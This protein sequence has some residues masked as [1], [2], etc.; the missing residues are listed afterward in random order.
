V[1][2][3]IRSVNSVLV[4]LFFS[5]GILFPQAKPAAAPQKSAPPPAKQQAAPPP[6]KAEPEEQI[7]PA[8]PDAI[9]PAVVARVNGRAVR[10][11][12]LE[13]RIQ[14][15]L[16]PMGNPKWTNLREE[17]RLELTNQQMGS[18]IAQEL[19]YQKA[20]AMAIKA[21][22][23]EIQ[24]EFDK[25][26]KSFAS[27]AEMNMT[28]ADRGLDRAG[29]TKELDRS[30]TVSKY[31]QETI[32]KKITITPAQVSEY[33][34]ANKQSFDHP[35]LIRTSHILIMVSEGATAEQDRLA[36]QRAAAI[37][38]RARKGEDFAKL[39]KENSM[40]NSASDGGDLGLVPRG[41][42]APEYEKA[43]FALP[44]G[45]ISDPVRT[46]FGYHVIKVTEKKPAGIASLEE[47][48][49]QLTEFLKS[50]KTDEEL[51]K[52]IDELRKQAKIEILIPLGSG[53]QAPG[54]TSTS[55]SRP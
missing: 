14:T 1:N 3:S 23:T 46:Q 26:A 31:V 15:Q 38:A 49:T 4:F 43:A 37:L 47:V 16:A 36:Q 44:V 24:A 48:R 10:G 54:I 20:S 22:A 5:L 9:F 51:Q 2:S 6:Q 41:Q 50:Q 30:L 11:R 7:P 19:I 32:G 17:Y 40:D 34:S 13:Q 42:L 18:L 29:L 25:V 53:G 12:D 52:V 35:E 28:L 33:Y 39:A 45:G 21:S 8:A 27:D 55:P